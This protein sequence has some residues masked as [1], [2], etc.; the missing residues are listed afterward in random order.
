MDY[1]TAVD[2]ILKF[3]DFERLPRS[4][5]VFDLK[6]IEKLLERLGHPERAAKTV[7]V[8]GTKGKGSTS[9]MIAS[10]L[11]QAGYRTGLY[12][13]PHLLD[14]R[15][16]VRINGAPISREAVAAI[17]EAI[18]PEIEYVN[19]LGNLGEL[20]T[21]ELLTALAFVY[22]RQAGADYQ[23]MEVGLGGR[24]DATNVV[25]P[26]VSVI[27]SISYDHMDVL[28]DTIAKIA[29]EKAGI[30]KPGRPVVCAPQLPEAMAVVERTCRERGSR[31][32]RIGRDVTWERR[33][34]DEAGQSFDLKIVA[35][36][37]RVLRI[38]L[39]G[40][41]QLDNAAAA[42]AAVGVLRELGANIPRGALAEGLARV[43][44][45]GRLQVLRQR[46]WL[47]IDGA[48]NA[49]SC[50]KLMEALREYFRFARLVLIFGASA[51]KH[52][53]GMA[54]ELAP[55]ADAVIVTSS[56]HPRATRTGLLV[57]EFRQR[58]KAPLVAGDVAAAL[59]MALSEAGPDDLIC[60]CG[61]IFLV[62]EVMEL[63]KA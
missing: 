2:Y 32:T 61:S 13:S 24:L 43:S 51:D 23:V 28:G 27:T 11:S 16:R 22:F 44:W 55:R 36:E 6:R 57:G 53:A 37:Y 5:V 54:A 4:G 63:L 52:V 38:P 8:T 1:Q 31:L 18:Q 58:G 7:H 60:A 20:T 42:A 33:D 30:I 62:A 59:A 29:A 45:P 3:A 41:F 14:M 39:L 10:I 35:G 9:A 25:T 50:A 12:T 56:R 21:F 34:F 15:E 26:E 49:Y 19:R 40:T 47:V 46:P 48:H 17:I